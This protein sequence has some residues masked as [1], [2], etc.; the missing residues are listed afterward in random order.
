MNKSNLSLLASVLWMLVGLSFRLGCLTCCE[1]CPMCIKSMWLGNCIIV[2][3]SSLV[4][5][6]L[7]NLSVY[8]FMID[9]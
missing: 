4:A 1:L 5:A 7:I 8:L 3:F 6:I 2:L 9:Y